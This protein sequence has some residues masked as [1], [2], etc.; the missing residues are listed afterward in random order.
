M[1]RNTIGISKR[2]KIFS[3]IPCSIQQFPSARESLMLINSQLP[4]SLNNPRFVQVGHTNSLWSSRARE[5]FVF[6]PLE[7]VCRRRH[8]I[9]E[10]RPRILCLVSG[11]ANFGVNVSSHITNTDPC[12]RWDTLRASTTLPRQLIFHSTRPIYAPKTG[13][14]RDPLF[15]HLTL[16]FA[17][18]SRKTRAKYPCNEYSNFGTFEN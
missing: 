12:S 9:G 7:P 16:R 11:F 2:Q 14:L 15:I 18:A 1:I 8:S 5:T 10:I 17:S 6:D 4:G 3:I 13:L